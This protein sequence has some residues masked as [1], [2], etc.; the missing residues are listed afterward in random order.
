MKPRRVYEKEKWYEYVRWYCEGGGTIDRW[1]GRATDNPNWENKRKYGVVG[2]T[3]YFRLNGGEWLHKENFK[4]Y[5]EVFLNEYYEYFSA[6]EIW[7]ER[8]IK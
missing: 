7:K 8:L 2:L 1:M 5:M 3:S 6:E 4:K